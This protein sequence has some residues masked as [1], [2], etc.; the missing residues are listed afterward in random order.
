MYDREG[1]LP[2]IRFAFLFLREKIGRKVAFLTNQQPTPI[3]YHARD[4]RLDKGKAKLYRKTDSVLPF[5]IL[6]DYYNSPS[7][8]S[9]GYKV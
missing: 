8:L 3:P 1:K 4:L 5:K 7:Y 2:V 6:R 9:L